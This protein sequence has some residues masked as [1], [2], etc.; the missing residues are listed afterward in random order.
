METARSISLRTRK[1]RF[2]G[3]KNLQTLL[4]LQER[5]ATSSFMPGHLARTV[6]SFGL[7]YTSI[8]GYQPPEII[9]SLRKAARLHDIGKGHPDI[10]PLLDQPWPLSEQDKV[11]YRKHPV[12]GYQVIAPIYGEESLEA[13]VT[14]NHH[15]WYDGHGYPNGL[16][17]VN[18][19]IAARVFAIVDAFDAMTHPRPYRAAKTKQKALSILREQAGSQF[20]PDYVHFVK[21]LYENGKI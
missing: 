15:E 18:I 1:K 9:E 16:A 17:G 14:L 4:N 13:L 7:V 10:F 2:A 12:F 20:D 11:I 3:E 8:F 19:P 5:L 6:D 21:W